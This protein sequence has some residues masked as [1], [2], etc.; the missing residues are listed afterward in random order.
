MGGRG[1]GGHNRLTEAQRLARGTWRRDRSESGQRPRRVA[2]EVLE[3]VPGAEPEPPA[4]ASR[5]E[6]RIWRATTA[7]LAGG[8]PI[9]E[10]TLQIYVRLKAR[11]ADRRHRPT[12]LELQDLRQAA[13]RLGIAAEED[14]PT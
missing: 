7:E 4:W 8:R 10:A 3:I 12:G 5:A 11:L 1:S 14:E 13:E 6:A 2:W 9:E